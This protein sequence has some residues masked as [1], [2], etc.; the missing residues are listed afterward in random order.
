[1]CATRLSETTQALVKDVLVFTQ[2]MKFN[3]EIFVG[4]AEILL[5]Y[6][7]DAKHKPE[8]ALYHYK[9]AIA[10]F[11]SKKYYDGLYKANDLAGGASWQFKNFQDANKYFKDALYNV[12][13]AEKTNKSKRSPKI[14]ELLKKGLSTKIKSAEN[15]NAEHGVQRIV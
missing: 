13:M 15:F 2:K 5:G 7:A 14:W 3:Q 4:K 8:D 1:M 12:V 9:K 10:S 11:E 6:L